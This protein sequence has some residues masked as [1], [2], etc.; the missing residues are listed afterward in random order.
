MIRIAISVVTTLLA[1]ASLA[2]ATYTLGRNDERRVR[3]T[4]Y[5][6]GMTAGIRLGCSAR[7]RAL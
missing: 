3:T 5:E 6:T 7:G 1:A 2:L 4:S